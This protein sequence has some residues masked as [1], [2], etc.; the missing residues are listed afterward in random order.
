[1]EDVAEPCSIAPVKIETESDKVAYDVFVMYTCL[2]YMC[3][4]IK[5]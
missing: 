3:T 5:T 1:M 2:R 4:T